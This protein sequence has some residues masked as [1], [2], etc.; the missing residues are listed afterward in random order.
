[1]PQE[2]PV[3]RIEGDELPILE[4]FLY[5]I[6]NRIPCRIRAEGDGAEVYDTAVFYSI[7]GDIGSIEHDIGSPVPVERELP[8]TSIEGLYKGKSR[9]RSVINYDK[10]RI[11]TGFFQCREKDTSESIISDFCNQCTLLPMLVQCCKHIRRSTSRIGF[12]HLIRLPA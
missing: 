12:K 8:L 3:V 10:R 5:H 11:N 7:K 1:M 9:Q 2:R 4:G 6:V